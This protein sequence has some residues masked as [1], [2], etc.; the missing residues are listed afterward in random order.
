MVTLV[1]WK[2]LFFLP[3]LMV[4]GGSGL[5]RAGGGAVLLERVQAPLEQGGHMAGAS[6]P[7][8]TSGS[9]MAGGLV[10]SGGAWLVTGEPGRGGGGRGW[11]GAGFSCCCP[12][13]TPELSLQTLGPRPPSR[14]GVP[15]TTMSGCPPGA[16]WPGQCDQRLPGAL[17]GQHRTPRGISGKVCVQRG[18]SSRPLAGPPQRRGSRRLSGGGSAPRCSR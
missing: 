10:G 11:A 2:L 18:R 9:D 1:I 6:G 16:A 14:T 8:G 15:A 7:L 13:R 3:P 12:C 4:F 5:G 17:G